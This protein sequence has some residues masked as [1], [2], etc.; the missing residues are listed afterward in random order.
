MGEF[1]FKDYEVGRKVQ[2]TF[3]TETPEATAFTSLNCEPISLKTMVNVREHNVADGQRHMVEQDIVTDQKEM[4]PEFTIAGI[5]EKLEIPFLLYLFFQNVSE[6]ADP[7]PKTFTFPATQGDFIVNAGYFA[8]FLVTAPTAAKD[9]AYKDCVCK[10][11]KLSSAPGERMKYTATFISRGAPNVDYDN[12]G[13]K[14]RNNGTFFHYS[15]IKIKTVDTVAMIF[16]GG[17]ELTLTQDVKG[18]GASGT[19]DFYSYIID[20]RRGVLDFTVL[21]NT[22][23]YA[24]EADLV[25]NSYVDI[26]LGYGN[27]TPGTDD[28]DFDIAV[29]GIFTEADPNTESPAG[30]QNKLIMAADA[31]VTEPITII[32]ADAVDQTW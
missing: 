25:A 29:H 19:G 2:A 14:T 22:E 11:L 10:E 24:Q 20:N 23:G 16:S 21:T 27:A 3:G 26:R 8:T 7:F 4:A 13:T 28:G 15:N 12:S 31:G 32:V 18:Y 1:S 6:G 17:W 9:H 30:Y 5:V